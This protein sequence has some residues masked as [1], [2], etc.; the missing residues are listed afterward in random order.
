[1]KFIPVAAAMVAALVPVAL[2]AAPMPD[3]A[4]DWTGKGTVRRNDSSD[5]IN[6]NCAITG[7][8]GQNEIG[9]KGNCRALLVVRR[10]IEATFKFVGDKVTG[11]YVGSPAGGPAELSGTAVSPT[12]W[13]IDM[14]FARP[15]NGDRNATMLIDNPGTGTFRIVTKDKVASGAEVTTTDV[16][17][18]KK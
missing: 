3:I 12:Q 17:F 5:P 11:T 8:Q 4:G 16:T 6:V 10:P 14:T 13:A 9:F 7:Q 15:V 1:M 18:T 2:A